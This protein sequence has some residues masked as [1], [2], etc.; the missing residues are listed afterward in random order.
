MTSHYDNGVLYNTGKYGI[1]HYA[2]ISWTE[3]RLKKLRLSSSAC[4]FVVEYTIEGT[5]VCDVASNLAE[6]LV[7]ELTVPAGA[8]FI[9]VF[10]RTFVVEWVT[11]QFI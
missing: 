3:I 6:T 9:E 10:E 2:V 7:A 8:K 11:L 5:L 1:D 4:K